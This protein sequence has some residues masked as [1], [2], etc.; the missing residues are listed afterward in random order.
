MKVCIQPQYRGP[1]E[2][3]GGIRRVVE[4]QQKWLPEFGIEVVDDMAKADLVAS[5]AGV[6]Q[7][8]PVAKPWVVHTHGLYWA[9][10]EWSRWYHRVNAEVIDAMKQADAVSAPSE[11]VAQALR[12]GMWL[13]PAVLPHGIDLEEW[14]PGDNKGYVLWNK[15]RPD[16]ICDPRVVTE[17]ATRMPHQPF[18]TTFGADADNVKVVGR[19]PFEDMK[20]LIASAGV[21]LCTTRE[22]F[23]IGTLE[24]MACGVPVVGWAWGGQREI[25]KHGETGWLVE[26]GDYD[27]LEEGTAWAIA[28]RRKVAD[29]ARDDV[30]RRFTWPTMIQRYAALY[31]AVVARHGRFH[32][33]KTPR[34]SVIIPCYNLAHFLPDTIAS[35]KAQ[36]VDDWEAV[37]VNDASP[38][39]TAA[40]ARD[41]AAADPRIRVV[42]NPKNLYLAGALNVGSEAALG[43]YVIPLDA[44]NMIGPRTLEILG[45]ALDGARDVDI[46][47]GSVQFV[48]E[49]GSTPDMAVNPDGISKW[50]VPFQFNQQMIH[51][52]QIPSTAMYRREVW[53]RSGGYR[54]RCKTAEDAEFW[55]RAVSLGFTPK[56]VTDQVTLIYR[57]RA[58]SMSRKEADWD[59]TAWFPWSQQVKL[60]PFGVPAAPPPKIN[61]GQS[62]PVPSAEPVRIA[63]II[64]VG[65]GHEEF[66]ID[67]LDSVEAQTFRQWEC[68]V[69]NDTGK[70]LEIPHPWARVMDTGGEAGPAKAR[71]I[72]ITASVAPLFVPLDAD[73][74]LQADAL[75]EFFA[76]WLQFRGT[77]YSQWWDDFGDQKRIYDPPEYD[78]QLLVQRGAIHAVTGLYPR[79]AWEEV[80]GF[81]ESLSHWEDWDFMLSLAKAGICGTK[82]PRP[83][84]NYRK[85]TGFRR[86]DNAAAFEAGKVAI[87]AKWSAL[88][89][90]KEALMACRGCPGGGGGRYPKPPS[91]Q[92]QARPE[93]QGAPR[94]GARDGYTVVAYVGDQA[95]TRVYKGKGT[96]TQYRFGATPAHRRKYVYKQ[97]LEGL[98]ALR[99]ARGRPIFQEMTLEAGGEASARISRTMEVPAVPVVEA[100]QVEP[101]AKPERALTTRELRSAVP[102]ADVRELERLL[103]TERQGPNRATAI[104]ILERA[105]RAKDAIPA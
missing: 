95:S 104:A 32:D 102:K 86:E 22:T 39:N 29:A 96:G 56:K 1:D 77:V 85:H 98:G 105:L 36:T 80:G 76:T 9:E 37:I 7:E 17:I 72:G 66:L 64:P 44:D 13:R 79:S 45:G 67:A 74:Y 10:Y 57:Q 8:V 93:G 21:Y 50:P 51:R 78:A 25:I 71:N 33:A 90:G 53:E 15:T 16:A 68:I 12:R 75:H 20:S 38:D 14:G 70:K 34:I 92:G 73:D 46:A 82:I 47:Y 11:W 4:A 23:G 94:M 100:V 63:V 27:G 30:A 58:D 81:D 5:H 18:V 101:E 42:T 65:P 87:L 41:L 84:F 55:T 89:E 62:W 2:G 6:L 59:W 40:V 91:T 48:L 49:D 54:R 52:N 83:L 43:R 99:D 35:L 69:I 88:W 26:P 28:N 61:N 97:D 24:A 31:E 19:V 103:A 60:T 3:D